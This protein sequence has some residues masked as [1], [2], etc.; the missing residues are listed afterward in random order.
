MRL[1]ALFMFAKFI[2]SI[3]SMLY[4]TVAAK[5]VKQTRI[6]TFIGLHYFN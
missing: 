2:V 4:S 5:K 6:W 3:I 1:E